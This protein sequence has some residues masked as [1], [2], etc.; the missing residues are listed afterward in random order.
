MPQF[1]FQGQGGNREAA[2]FFDLF[3]EVFYFPFKAE[4]KV[5]NQPSSLLAAFSN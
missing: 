5:L 1:F 4:F 3:V 2:G